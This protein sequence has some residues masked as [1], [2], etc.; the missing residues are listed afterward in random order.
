M[1]SKVDPDTVM[2]RATDWAQ[3]RPEWGLAKNAT[4]IVGSRELT[5]N[6][7]LEGRA[8]LHSYNWEQ[9]A[10]GKSLSTILTAPM[11]VAHWINMQ[12]LFSTLDNV[13]FG[14]GSKTTQNV[15]GKIGI[16]QGNASDFMH[17]LSLQSVYMSDHQPYHQA[18]RLTVV[19]YAPKALIDAIIEQQNILQELFGNGS[20]HMICYD[21]K[22]QQKFSLQR[23]LTWSELLA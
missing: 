20:I 23:D 17:G 8:F 13:A 21:P 2:V 3:V 18:V 6:L 4:F 5:K 1:G 11:V 15:T 9:D 7:N 22:R 10:N 19:V 14:G 16:M 12:Y